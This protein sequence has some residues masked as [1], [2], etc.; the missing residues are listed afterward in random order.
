LNFSCDED[1]KWKIISK[2]NPRR[3]GSKPLKRL[4]TFQTFPI[5]NIFL[6][7][8]GFKKREMIFCVDDHSLGEMIINYSDQN[9]IN[10]K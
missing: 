2:E 6:S 10:A 8:K 4:L 5:L 7:K 9:Y 1:I 3:R